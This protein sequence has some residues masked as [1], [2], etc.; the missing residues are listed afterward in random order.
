MEEW[1]RFW[2]QGH[3]TTFGDYFSNGYA[4]P[5]RD[6]LDG[7]TTSLLKDRDSLNVVELCCGNGSLLPFLLSLNLPFDYMGVDA[8]N[9]ELPDILRGAVDQAKGNIALVGNTPVEDLPYNAQ[10][11]STC[12]SIYG[13]EYSDLNKTLAGVLPRMIPE[14]QLFAL[15]HHH[16]S[17]VA[18]MSARAV[19]EYNEKDIAA[20][21]DALTAINTTFSKLGNVEALKADA[22]AEAAR[23]FV[24]GMGNKYV[25]GATLETGNAFMADHVLAALRFFKLLGQKHE[26]RAHFI[27]ELENEASA[28][29]VRHQQ[30]LSVASTSAEMEDLVDQMSTIGWRD[31]QHTELLHKGDIIGW[32]LTASA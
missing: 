15:L 10:N 3:T 12:L 9:I 29:R 16:D 20:I 17:V 11:I 13:M 25:R 19:S 31:A 4:G 26:V 28:A 18:R 30:M 5:V 6:W 2:R 1:S 32:T 14:G 23:K 7:I 27:A 24:N 8:A 21:R 22:D